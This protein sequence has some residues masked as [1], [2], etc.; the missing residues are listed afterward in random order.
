M[1]RN[2]WLWNPRLWIDAFVLVNLAFLTGDIYLAHS[3][4]EFRHWAENVPYYFSMFSPALLLIALLAFDGTGLSRL[5]RDLGH[6]VGWSALGIGLAGVL[7]H[8]QSQFFVDRTLKSLVY[9]APF[10]AP[11][12]FTGL[13]LLLIMN[14]MI[15]PDSAEWSQWVIL[16]A[17]GGFAGNFVFSLTDHAQ[18]G[19]FY[20]TEWIPVISSAMAVGFLIVPLLARVDRRYVRLC[21]LVLGL[22]A[23]VGLA[24]FI[25]H[26][27]AN[28]HGP[29]PDM[30]DNFIY[31]APAMA[32]LL[33][34]NLVLLAGIGLWGLARRLPG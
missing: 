18:N 4:N 27:S 31:G 19:F 5:W 30:F 25:L 24:G 29:S 16:L 8:L 34:P 21:A 2:S 28:L 26:T 22:Q 1:A 23:L 20:V 10:A 12:A 15:H 14:R 17:L 7:F 6:V 9:A 32:P 33:F 3:V 11:L 13:G